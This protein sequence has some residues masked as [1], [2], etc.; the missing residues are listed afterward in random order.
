[1]NEMALLETTSDSDSV[2]SVHTGPGSSTSVTGAFE[3]R[4]SGAVAASNRLSAPECG[5]DT[6]GA[7]L[8]KS[9]TSSSLVDISESQF[10]FS[11]ILLL[12]IINKLS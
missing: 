10:W 6:A 12:D 4:C 11:C 8:R 9:R 3:H 7:S 2:V 1:M 5:S